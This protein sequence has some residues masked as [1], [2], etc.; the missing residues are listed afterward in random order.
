MSKS[1]ST[2]E[3]ANLIKDGAIEIEVVDS[4]WGKEVS[5]SDNRGD[6]KYSF[7]E[8]QFE[9]L[10]TFLN[11]YDNII[12]D[13]HNKEESY[14]GIDLAW[15]IG[16]IADKYICE[17]DI[18]NGDFALITDLGHSGDGT[19]TG[20]MRNI[21]NIFPDQNYSSDHF[22]KS[23]MCE[24]TQ[25]VDEETVVVVNENAV[26]YDIDVKIPELRAIRDIN[27]ADSG[28]ENAVQNALERKRFKTM[29]VSELTDVLYDA[30]LLLGE[31]DVSK[32][33]IKELVEE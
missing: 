21:Y 31:H 14:D 2:R 15:H 8:K 10:R 6:S 26:K 25:T 29:S 32:M 22:S 12:M 5:M 30:H 7:S 24:L 28:L 33:D 1:Q 17:E 9:Q 16:K 19:Y 27:N 13:I 4:P 18:T 23:T 20:Q 3:F 11:N